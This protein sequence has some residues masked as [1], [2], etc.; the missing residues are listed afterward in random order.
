VQIATDGLGGLLVTGC[1]RT[2]ALAVLQ[3]ATT[4]FAQQHQHDLRAFAELLQ[5]LP[6]SATPNISRSRKLAQEMGDQ[7]NALILRD[8]MLSTSGQPIDIGELFGTT[9]GPPTVSVISLFALNDLSAQAAFIGR[10]AMAVFDWIRRNPARDG[11]RGLFVV[12]EAAPFLPR[13]SSE[14]KDALM[15]LCQQ[16]GVGLLLATQ[17][18]MDLDYNATAQFATQFFGTANQPQ[19]VR[20]IEDVMEQR[21]L[22][23]LNPSALK[24]GWFYVSA[25]SLKQPVK[26]QAPMCFSWHPRNRTLTDDEILERV[27]RGRVG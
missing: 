14:S 26:L 10:L 18:P 16:Y 20:F 19:V 27:R 7:L 4:H 11:L 15:L 9:G 6:E 5:E 25:P 13:S 21:G 17:N 8:P 23:N 12:D 22:R 2:Q 24:P 1:N 3:V